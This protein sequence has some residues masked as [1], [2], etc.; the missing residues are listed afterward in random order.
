MN[1]VN[2]IQNHTLTA[3]RGNLRTTTESG[4]DM[5]PQLSTLNRIDVSAK[6][7]T[8][9]QIAD[10]L[11]CDD[12]NNA[13]TQDAIKNDVAQMESTG[14]DIAHPGKRHLQRQTR[15]WQQRMRETGCRRQQV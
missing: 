5:S 9:E 4:I 11:I 14:D 15:S 10:V 7:Q 8:V 13:S 6:M 2:S 3:Y 12:T 1:T